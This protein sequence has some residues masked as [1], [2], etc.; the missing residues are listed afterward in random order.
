MKMDDDDM[1]IIESDEDRDL[2]IDK[3]KYLGKPRLKAHQK[4]VLAILKAK[5]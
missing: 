5:K 4:E 3:E 2:H 1:S